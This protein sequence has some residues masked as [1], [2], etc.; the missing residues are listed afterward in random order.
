L[1][2][3]EATPKPSTL[4]GEESDETSSKESPQSRAAESSPQ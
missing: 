3:T 2:D 4:A 1:S